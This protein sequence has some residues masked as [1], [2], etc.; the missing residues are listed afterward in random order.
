MLTATHRHQK[1]RKKR[2][3]KQNTLHGKL[4]I[5]VIANN[6]GQTCLLAE[7]AANKFGTANMLPYSEIL[8]LIKIL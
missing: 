1:Q 2:P 7:Y 3:E 6:D 5:N 8:Y 4:L